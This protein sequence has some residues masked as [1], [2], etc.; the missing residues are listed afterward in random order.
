MR[1]KSTGDVDRYGSGYHGLSIEECPHCGRKTER[2][3]LKLPGMGAKSKKCPWC[4]LGPIHRA[5]KSIRMRL[6]I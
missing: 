4:S 5:V 2:V 1:E 3:T 6:G